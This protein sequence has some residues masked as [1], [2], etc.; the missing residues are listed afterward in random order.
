MNTTRISLRLH[1]RLTLA[2]TG[3]VPFH[4]LSGSDHGMKVDRRCCVVVRVVLCCHWGIP[5]TSIAEGWGCEEY[6]PAHL[7]R[8]A[9]EDHRR[10]EW[11]ASMPQLVVGV[12]VRCD[13][14]ATPPRDRQS[15]QPP[16][17]V[18]HSRGAWSRP[19]FYRS[20]I[21]RLS[22]RL[23]SRPIAVGNLRNRAA[24]QIGYV[25]KKSRPERSA[26]CDT[27]QRPSNGRLAE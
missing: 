6:D 8:I 25:H 12:G 20:T 18:V 22:F 15:K 14:P 27:K 17:D 21:G 11:Y 7:G 19:H 26:G 3:V 1:P 2:D 24:I 9:T 16:P 10:W 4:V 23:G 5:K 13:S